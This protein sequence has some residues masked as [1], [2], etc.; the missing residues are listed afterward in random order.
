MQKNSAK[1]RRLRDLVLSL[2][3]GTG[4]ACT[5][6]RAACCACAGLPLWALLLQR[7]RQPA[8]GCLHPVKL[9][10]SGQRFRVSSTSAAAASLHPAGL[11]RLPLC[12]HRLLGTQPRHLV[13]A[14]QLSGSV[15]GCGLTEAGGQGEGGT[16]RR[17]QL[18]E[19]WVQGGF[20]PA[21]VLVISQAHLQREQAGRWGAQP[22][23]QLMCRR[24]AGSHLQGFL[25][26]ASAY[27]Q[28]HV[29]PQRLQPAEQLFGGDIKLGI[30]A[31]GC[32]SRNLAAT[33]QA[34][35]T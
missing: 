11:C 4:M 25:R 19:P 32:R 9:R 28:Q 23:G 7:Q 17:P 2:A 29:G 13:L 26:T 1:V 20:V 31:A 16:Q 24:V 15:C 27:W 34:D 18:R 35:Y 12:C 21:A 30:P 6:G 8:C 14:D 10:R 33:P 3:A 5:G 22:R